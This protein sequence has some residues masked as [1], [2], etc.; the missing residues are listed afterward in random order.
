[1][2]LD[3]PEAVEILT[4]KLKERGRKLE[5]IQAR[6]AELQPAADEHTKLVLARDA[7]TSRE[8]RNSTGGLRVQL[9][10]ALL[11][12]HIGTDH[13]SPHGEHVPPLEIAE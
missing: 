7:L 9:A 4:A 10:F 11:Y 6:I 13:L 1:M 8:G 12:R 2:N 5:E 3:H